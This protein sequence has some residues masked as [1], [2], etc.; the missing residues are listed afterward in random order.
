M[1]LK[2]KLCAWSERI[3]SCLGFALFAVFSCLFMCLLCVCYVFVTCLLYLFSRSEQQC[4]D[5]HCRGHG[6]K[7]SS[8]EMNK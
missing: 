6:D 2:P 4:D 5:G 3:I 8:K 1:R 7:R